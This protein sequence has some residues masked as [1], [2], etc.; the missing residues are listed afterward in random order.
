M[1]HAEQRLRS[2]STL[3]V[4]QAE[5]VAELEKEIGLDISDR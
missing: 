4:L 5:E 3:I 2:S 1:L